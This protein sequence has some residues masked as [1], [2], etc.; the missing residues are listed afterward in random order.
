MD[1]KTM[2]QG[3]TE[4]S[5]EISSG[6]SRKLFACFK[7]NQMKKSTSLKII[8]RFAVLTFFFFASA[9]MQNLNAQDCDYQ[10]GIIT[11]N[12]SGQNITD[13]Y[14]TQYVLTNIVGDILSL[15]D[16]TRFPIDQEGY[17]V[18]YG[19]NYKN[20]STV[21][22]LSLGSNINVVEGDCIDIGAPFPIAVCE[23]LD[24]CNYCLGETVV[25]EASSTNNEAGFTTAYI[26]ADKEGVISVIQDSPDFG[27][28]EEGLYV[29]FAINYDTNEGINGLEVGNNVLDINGTCFDLSSGYIFGVCQSLDPTIFFDLKGCDITQTAILQV[30]EVYD[31]YTWSTG[32]TQSFIEVDANTPAVYTVTVS[33]ATGCIGIQEQ[34]ITGEEVAT[35]GDFVWEDDNGNGLQDD[36]ESGIN[37]VTVSLYADFNNDGVPDFPDF[38]SCITTTIDDPSSGE[39]G[40]YIFHVYQSNYIIGFDGPSGFT[41]SESGSGNNAAND[42][43]PNPATG[44]TSTISVSPGQVI[45]DIDA[46][47]YTSSG[48]GG[49][50]WNDVNGNG[51]QD[52]GEEG[53][54]DVVI[55]IYDESGIL[56]NSLST[57]TDTISGE[58]GAYCFDEIPPSS[59][60]TEIILPDGNVVSPPNRR[61]N[62]D[63]D[64]DA[65]NSNGLNTTQLYNLSPGV[66]T[67]NVDF[68]TYLGGTICGIVWRELGAQENSTYDAGIDELIDDTQMELI[69]ID[70]DN[71]VIDVVATN[72]NGEYC[73]V[74]VPMGSYQVRPKASDAGGSYVDKD[75]GDDNLLDSDIDPNTIATD[76]FFLDV[77]EDRLGV[78]AGLRSGA[79]PVELVSFDG[80]WDIKRNANL[81]EWTTAIEIN[82][83]KFIIERAVGDNGKFVAIGEVEGNGTTSELIDYQFIDT[84]IN[85]SATYYY[86]LKQVDYD[87]GFDYSEIVVIDI[88]RNEN[89]G[90]NIYPNPA[91][92]FVTIDLNIED[93]SLYEA[94]LYDIT[95]RKVSNWAAKTILKGNS[96]IS[97]DISDIPMGQYMLIITIGTKHNNQLL[98]IT[99]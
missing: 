96:E 59:F 46:G 20:G 49:T 60:Y 12:A 24:P 65:D 32:S 92:S 67:D 64:S 51:V 43:D 25:L 93:G 21:T 81:L 42:S 89:V 57:S 28:L 85:L 17:Y 11:F 40:Y 98:L 34:R 9:S 48:I 26:L 61:A 83:D 80:S 7:R 41:I 13:L 97:L 62:D 73:F 82:N 58:V 50:V 86:R 16:E 53:I 68:G 88:E 4:A 55:N 70:N 14:T 76:V 31:S 99:K 44:L 54:N 22:G 2:I 5:V 6:L 56:I 29:A 78:N 19:V 33:L 38:P 23:A 66:K 1:T 3:N 8:I 77:S 63:I 39:P 15:S 74:G 71:E 94:E 84:E 72:E 18:I 36:I 10:T 27:Q 45:T 95:G 87:G 69:S 47:F 79:L 37:G 91:S 30:G 75:N 35:I 52:D 90:I